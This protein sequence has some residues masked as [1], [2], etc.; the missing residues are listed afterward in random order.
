MAGVGGALIGHVALTPA[1]LA[2]RRQASDRDEGGRPGRPVSAV[3]ECRP[4]YIRAAF[5]GQSAPLWTRFWDSLGAP[6]D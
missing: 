5:R 2:Q 4:P 3:F 6:R 1:L